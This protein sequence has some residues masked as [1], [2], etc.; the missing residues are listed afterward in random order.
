[1]PQPHDTDEIDTL[2]FCRRNF[3]NVNMRSRGYLGKPT[4]S[5]KK[6]VSFI[7]SDYVHDLTLTWPKNVSMNQEQPANRAS[8]PRTYSHPGALF[9]TLDLRQPNASLKS[10]RPPEKETPSALEPVIKH[11]E[12]KACGYEL[13][14]ANTHIFTYIR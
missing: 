1:M 4:T 12:A 11:C 7:R 10:K 9:N 8:I 13:L 5:Y 2:S 3:D 14:F 6:I